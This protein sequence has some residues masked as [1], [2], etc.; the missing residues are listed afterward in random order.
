LTVDDSF[1]DAG[2]VQ[3]QEYKEENQSINAPMA[4]PPL[5]L[6]AQPFWILFIPF[7]VTMLQFQQ[8]IPGLSRHGMN[9]AYQT[10][11]GEWWRTLTALTLHADGPHLA[12]NLLSGYFVLSLLAARI[13]LSRI[14]P[15]LFLASALANFCVA[16]TVQ[17]DFRSLG[18]STFV[19]ASLGTLATIE[20]RLLPREKT[21]GIFKR[22][23]PVISAG[24]LAVMMGLGENSDILAHGYGFLAGL[25]TGMLP[26]KKSIQGR[27]ND[28]SGIDLLAIASTYLGIIIA[29]KM[30]LMPFSAN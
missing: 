8:R 3:L 15:Q 26:T 22:A 13:P 23:E 9:D 28:W 5:M 20:W 24:F 30:A 16:L 4:L 25:F 18:F 10:L 17:S 19:F 11:H 27:Q 14:A 7:A 2:R 12:S 6:S 1:A 21:I 29:W